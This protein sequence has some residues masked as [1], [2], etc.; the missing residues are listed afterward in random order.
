MVRQQA[1]SLAEKIVNQLERE[2]VVG[3][4]PHAFPRPQ[5]DR[6]KVYSD[7]ERHA[8]AVYL[9]D[10]GMDH[11]WV[12][13]PL[14]AEAYYKE[15]LR[16]DPDHADAWVH[17]GNR[18]LEEGRGVEALS[19]YERGQAAA[20]RRTIGDPDRY[21]H[22]FGGDVDSRPFMRALHGR[23]LCLWRLGRTDE[24][25]HIFARMLKLNPNDNQVTR[26]LIA[27]LDEGLSWEK[28]AEKDE[29]HH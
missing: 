22:S 21:P 28:S 2:Q 15:A 7:S 11:L 27:D 5:G 23:E 19:L 29:P 26:F 16:L 10:R 14:Q 25:R 1:A 8:W 6:R 9:F 20:E 3:L 17:L 13:W 4:D 18:C 24:A 12:G